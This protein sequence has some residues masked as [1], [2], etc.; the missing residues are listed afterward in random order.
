MSYRIPM[1]GEPKLDREALARS[2]RESAPRMHADAQRVLEEAEAS[3]VKKDIKQAKSM[4]KRTQA[5]MDRL[6][7]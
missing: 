3:G 5:L 1:V 7:D 2:L 4:L 6:S